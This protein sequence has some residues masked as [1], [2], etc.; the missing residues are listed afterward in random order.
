[1]VPEYQ[2]KR[3]RVAAEGDLTLPASVVTIGGF[4]GVH[5]G[6][7]ALISGVIRSARSMK[8]PAGPSGQPDHPLPT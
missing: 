3:V 1:M 8:V 4:D 5:R 7:Q 6:H 2:G